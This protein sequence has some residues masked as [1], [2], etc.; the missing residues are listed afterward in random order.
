ML[1]MQL[2]IT[3]KGKLDSHIPLK[4]QALGQMTASIYMIQYNSSPDSFIICSSS[5]NRSTGLVTMVTSSDWALCLSVSVCRC[6]VV[7]MNLL[8]SHHVLGAAGFTNADFQG[9]KIP[10]HRCKY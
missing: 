2:L 9:Y 6:G 10:C 7:L 5:D 1:A 4:V 3:L 8:A